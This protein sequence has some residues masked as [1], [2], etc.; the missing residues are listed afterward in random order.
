MSR[1]AFHKSKLVISFFRFYF[2]RSLRKNFSCLRIKGLP[3]ALNSIKLST[4]DK[5]P[6]IFCANHSSWW[7][8]PLI[9]YLTYELFGTDSYC[10]MEKK[11]F[12]M[13]PYFRG[14][15]AVPIVREDA[16]NSLKVL[17]DCAAEIN[18]KAKSLWIFPQGEIIPNS[19]RPFHFY[20]GLSI[21]MEKLS[22]PVLACL[23]FDYRFTKNQFPETFVNIFKLGG[24]ESYEGVTRDE[25]T[26][27]L[28]KLYE[29]QATEFEISFA[30]GKLGDYE[31]FFEGR[32]SINEKR[33][34]KFA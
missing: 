19:K 27:N 30:N 34:T 33:F 20:P 3:E 10:I 1:K 14:F 12:D 7:D 22:D 4:E 18:G 23:Y 29:K 21:L 11:Q 15:G 8:A 25:F 5:R 26:N 16:R 13:H 31:V 24:R 17:N 6:V 28:S 32:K 2:S 9:F